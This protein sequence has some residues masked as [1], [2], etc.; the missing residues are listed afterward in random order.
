M[1]KLMK[2]L[3][4]LLFGVLLLGTFWFLWQKTRPVRTIYT[5]VTPS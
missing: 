2:I 5:L 1:K 3:L 4:G